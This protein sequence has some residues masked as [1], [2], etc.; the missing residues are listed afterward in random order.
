LSTSTGHAVARAGS[1]TVGELLGPQARHRPRDVAISDGKRQLDYATLNGRVDRLANVLK[2]LGLQR[3]ARIAILSENRIEYLETVFAAARL[4]V[5]VCCLNWRLAHE[6]LAHCVGLVEP[7]AMIVSERFDRTLEAIGWHGQTLR[8]G[9]D[10][11]ARLAAASEVAPAVEAEPEDGLLILYTSGTTGLPKGALISHRAELARMA[12]SR[13]DFGL[14]EGDGFVAWAP[15]FHMVSLEHAIHVLGLGGQVFVVDG[16]DIERIV[17]LVEA[18]R[19]WWLVLIPGMAERVVQ[20]VKD[21]GIRPKGLKVAGALADLFPKQLIAETSRLLEAP[22]WNTFGSTETGMMPVAGTRF[23]PGCEPDTLAKAHNSLYLWRLVD[24]DDHDV[25]RGQP[26]EIAVR[27]PTVFSGYWNAAEVNAREFRSGWF[28]MGD[29]FVEQPDG[30][31]QY[32]DRSKYLIKSGGENIYPAEIE[33]VLMA[34]ARVAEAVVVKRRDAKWGEV[35]VAF[36]ALQPA[37][38]MTSEELMQLCRARLSSYKCPSEV[39][40]VESQDRFPRG[41]SGKVQRQAVEQWAEESAA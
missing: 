7:A 8:L 28:H 13:M 38:R 9:S 27:G 34:D 12:L 2:G 5:I 36:V 4:G 30:R 6:E 19:Q 23:A 25:P 1:L 10:Y 41:T 3:G 16:A 32:V 31:L 39:R 18:E 29:L 22:Y 37:A 21:R 20:A 26:G 24:A 15:M 40:L 11:E 14:A 17:D 33:R 35:P